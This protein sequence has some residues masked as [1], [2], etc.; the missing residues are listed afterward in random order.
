MLPTRRTTIAQLL[1]VLALLLP[2]TSL[3]APPK[4]DTIEFPDLVDPSRAHQLRRG[5][6][7]KAGLRRTAQPGDARSGLAFANQRHTPSPL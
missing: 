4:A 6:A 3:A 7:R 2:W 1:A 5:L